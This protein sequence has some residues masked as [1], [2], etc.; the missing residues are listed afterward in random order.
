MSEND[1]LWWKKASDRVEKGWRGIYMAKH[2][3]VAPNLI[4]GPIPML[5]LFDLAICLKA[6]TCTLPNSESMVISD[7]LMLTPN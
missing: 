6:A 7:N 3:I 5:I 1:I 4:M 2:L